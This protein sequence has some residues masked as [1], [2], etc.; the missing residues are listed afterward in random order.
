VNRE[1]ASEV[2]IHSSWKDLQASGL[3][4][5]FIVLCIGIWLHAADSLVTATIAPAIVEDIGGVIYINWTITLYEVGAIVAAAATPV[6]SQRI[7]I[8]RVMLCATLLYGIGCIIGGLAPTMSAL[9]VGRLA[10]GMGGGMLLSLCY[11]AIQQWFEPAWWSRMFGIVAVIWGTG[12]LLGPLFGGIFVALHAWRATFLLFAVEAAALWIMVILW[13]PPQAPSASPRKPWPLLP[14]LV[15]SAATLLIAESSVASQLRVSILGAMA[16]LG[17]LYWAARLDRGSASRLFPLQIL[18]FGHPVGAGLLMVFALS[19]AAT[20]FWA[21]GPLLLKIMFGTPPLTSGYI[22]ALEG[23]A[24]SLATLAVSKAPLSADRLLIRVGATLVAAGAGGFALV[25]PNGLMGG[26]VLCA[27][28]QGLG[29]GLCWPSIVHRMAR[30]SD[31]D[32]R[33]LAVTSPETIQRIGYAVG[34]AAVG[35]A[36]NMSGLAAGISVTAAKTAAFW[37]FAAFMPILLVALIAAWRF[38]AEAV[39]PA[40]AVSAETEPPI[41]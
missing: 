14:L 16:G 26:V 21:Y 10:Q 34:A 5:R 15:L 23:I 32:Q 18:D 40:V 24:W 39:P 29:F 17:L 1:A 35:I 19:M 12:S 36:A 27:M 37:V 30:L 6:L 41:R 20:G 9:L 4:G 28:L 13:L 2:V 3:L 33:P 31:P 7:G 38:T 25:M 22:L 8:K 11:L